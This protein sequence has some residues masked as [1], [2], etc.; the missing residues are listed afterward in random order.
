MTQ[1]LLLNEDFDDAHTKM[2]KSI[3]DS[4]QHLLSILQDILD[5]TAIE[6]GKLKIN[7]E[8]FSF[9]EL[10]E[11]LIQTFKMKTEKKALDFICQYVPDI[12]IKSD[13]T[14]I[15]QIL[16]NLFMNAVKYT[17]E[18]FVKCEFEIN[19]RDFEIKII[20]SGVGIP[21]EKIDMIFKAFTQLESALTRKHGGVGLGLYLCKRLSDAIEAELKVESENQKGSTFILKLPNKIVDNEIDFSNELNNKISNNETKKHLYIRY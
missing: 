19:N 7:N 10:F 14:K 16:F 9:E 1:I 20:D 8:I 12:K 15:K 21:E 2:L 17:D 18:G 3:K 11:S 4:G 5:I 6:S 13:K